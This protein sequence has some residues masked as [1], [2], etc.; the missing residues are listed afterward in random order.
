MND[1]MFDC[2]H[3]EKLKNSIKKNIG[4][5]AFIIIEKQNAYEIHVLSRV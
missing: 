5:V 4:L 2:K 3:M 1:H